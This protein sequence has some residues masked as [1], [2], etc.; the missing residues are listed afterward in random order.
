MIRL[1]RALYLS[2][3]TLISPAQIQDIV[4]VSRERNATVD[5]TGVLVFSGE[6]FAQVLEGSAPALGSLM[7]SIRRDPRHVIVHEWP[8]APAPERWYAEWSM[9][10]LYNDRLEDLAARLVGEP[11]PPPLDHLVP[12]LFLGLDLNKRSVESAR[13]H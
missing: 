11:T 3:A 5:V 1:S 2:R 6:H 8:L 4:Q 7:A 12:T 13:R 10:Y 9:G